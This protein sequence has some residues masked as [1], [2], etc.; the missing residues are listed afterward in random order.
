V[1]PDAVWGG[2]LGW[3]RDRIGVLDEGD[4]HRRQKGSFCNEFGAS[5]FNQRGHAFVVKEFLKRS[6]INYWRNS[7]LVLGL[8]F[9]WKPVGVRTLLTKANGGPW[10]QQFENRSIA[11]QYF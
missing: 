2:E 4:Y 3:L 1:D 6:V 9:R 10:F 5:H 11:Q 7:A 8:D